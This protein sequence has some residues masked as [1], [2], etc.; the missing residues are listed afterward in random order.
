MAANV[1]AKGL[2]LDLDGTVVDTH[3]LIFQCYDRTMREHCGCEGN[4]HV[5]EKCAGLHL[6]D[7]FSA[8]LEHFG[9]PVC[10]QKI[11]EAITIYRSHL[12]DNESA[13][14]TFPG[15][16]ESLTE[17]CRRG[18]RLAIV[19][20]KSREAAL[21]HLQS[22]QLSHLFDGVVAG[23]DCTNLKPHP[24]PFL[25]ALKLL[26][27]DP[28]SAIG[29]G[30][31]EHDIHSA[32]AAGLKTVGACW[33]TISRDKLLAANPDFLAEHPKELLGMPMLV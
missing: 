24:E 10:R 5:L 25:K 26:G 17:L 13:V 18:W 30:D 29:V 27:V 21:R 15:V 28:A 33:G 20:T 3:E 16:T 32:R 6:H 11:T 1:G 8:T 2:L 19:T 14:T 31:S 22:Q 12:R 7:I 4:R 9:V 23:D